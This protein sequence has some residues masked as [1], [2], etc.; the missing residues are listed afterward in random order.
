MWFSNPV[1]SDLLNAQGVTD[2]TVNGPNSIWVDRGR[3]M[4]QVEVENSG[5]T[6]PGD[7]RALALSLA[8]FARSRLDDACPIV[9]ARLVSEGL[10]KDVRLHAVLSPIA[11]INAGA[12]I[13]LRTSC[14]EVF[15]LDALEQ[16]GMLTGEQCLRLKQSVIDSE[17]IIVS[18][19]TSSG[20]TTLLSALLSFAPPK[21]RIVSVEE[22]REISGRL[23]PGLVT[24][25]A[26]EANLEG[27]GEVSLAALLKATLRMRPD[28]I[29]LGECR[30]EEVREFLLALSAGYSGSITTLHAHSAGDVMKRLEMLGFTAGVPSKLVRMQVRNHIDLIVH[31]K[32]VEGV[33]KVVEMHEVQS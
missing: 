28:Q 12:Y 30:G 23:H 24:L 9:D 26:R 21:R 31:L 17:N 29:V 20:K 7:V 33:R 5:L 6:T 16:K 2:M 22:A 4:E 32:N 3:G 15:S 8:R 1:L 10:G 14:E 13:S 11:D 18:G 25:S 19:A 27:Q